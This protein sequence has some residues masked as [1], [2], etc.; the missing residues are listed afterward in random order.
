MADQPLPMAP[1]RLHKRAMPSA[2]APAD[3]DLLDRFIAHGDQAAFAALVERH[4]PMVY[5]AAIKPVKGNP[6]DFPDLFGLSFWL[7]VG[8]LGGAGRAVDP[9]YGL[10]LFLIV[11][12]SAP[13]KLVQVV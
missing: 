7:T 2:N 12:W 10:E 8:G 4:G 11:G 13:Q 1:H 6:P 5:G 3:H 9:A